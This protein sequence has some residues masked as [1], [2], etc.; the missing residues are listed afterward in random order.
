MGNILQIY[1]NQTTLKNKPCF[2]YTELA[3]T[4]FPVPNTNNIKLKWPATDL[5]EMDVFGKEYHL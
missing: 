5:L 3:K 2:L 4:L 1:V